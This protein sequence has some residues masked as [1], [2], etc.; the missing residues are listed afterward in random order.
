MARP[1][2]PPRDPRRPSNAGVCPTTRSTGGRPA[3]TERLV[4]AGR[5]RAA[6]TT[7]PA[8]TVERRRA[9][10]DGPGMPG[11]A[12]AAGQ[13]RRH[14][15]GPDR[16]HR[17]RCGQPRR[18]GDHGP[19]GRAAGAT[20]SFRRATHEDTTR[21]GA[22]GANGKLY[23]W[24]TYYGAGGPTINRQAVP[25][26]RPVHRG[27]HQRARPLDGPDVRWTG[28]SVIAHKE[29]TTNRP[30]PRLDMSVDRAD[31]DWCLTTGPRR[32]TAGS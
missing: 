11:P 22:I 7:T 16:H 19:A 13:L 29:W 5:L 30:D 9:Q 1:L 17:G 25:R 21:K 3:R 8:T 10:D 27:D 4:P 28:K 24:E 14:P 23:G 12:R 26:A 2:N 31:V 15:R 6:C 32:P 20:T 18:R